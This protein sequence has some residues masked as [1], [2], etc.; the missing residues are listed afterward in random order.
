M[1]TMQAMA[2]DEFGATLKPTRVPVRE[3]RE[4]EVLI[5]VAAA[6]V[7]PADVGMCQG[8]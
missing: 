4:G 3:P 1:T 8:R 6:A 7:N 5:R 2:V